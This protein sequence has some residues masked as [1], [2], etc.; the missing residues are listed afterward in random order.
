[1][2]TPIFTTSSET[3]ACALSAKTNGAAHSSAEPMNELTNPIR[4]IVIL[5]GISNFMAQPS[6]NIGR[7]TMACMAAF[8]PYGAARKGGVRWRSFLMMA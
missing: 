4:R 1:V 7:S 6:R 8:A 3:C 2:S 5:P